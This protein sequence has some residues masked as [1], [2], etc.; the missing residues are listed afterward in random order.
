M[1]LPSFAQM[2]RSGEIPLAARS[3]S[4]LRV[5]ARQLS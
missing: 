5:G 3:S 1:V 2:G 4:T